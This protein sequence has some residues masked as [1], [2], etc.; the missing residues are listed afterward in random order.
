[1]I[2]RE[3]GIDLSKAKLCVING[4][5][6]LGILWD[7]KQLGKVLVTTG[8]KL[9]INHDL[10]IRNIET[11]KNEKSIDLRDFLLEVLPN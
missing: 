11:G 2:S 5:N 3:G 6:V 9:N 10:V 1:M 4:E 8:E 7:H